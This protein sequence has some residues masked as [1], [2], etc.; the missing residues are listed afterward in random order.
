V[1]TREGGLQDAQTTAADSE[2]PPHHHVGCDP[3]PPSQQDA[4]QKTG[5]HWDLK[6][7]SWASLGGL[8]SKQRTVHSLGRDTDVIKTENPGR[9]L[10]SAGCIDE[11]ASA[12][13]SRKTSQ[14]QAGG[15]FLGIANL[16][17][18]KQH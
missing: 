4:L 1:V 10:Q 12:G 11:I 8:F 18:L 9:C 7:S 13:R 17:L 6:N 5:H 2:T 15:Y 16:A 14:G 3:P